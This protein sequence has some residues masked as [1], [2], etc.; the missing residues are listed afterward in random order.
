MPKRLSPP[1]PPHPHTLLKWGGGLETPCPHGSAAYAIFIESPTHTPATQIFMTTSVKTRLINSYI[2]NYDLCFIVIDLII[3]V[4]LTESIPGVELSCNQE[5]PNVKRLADKDCDKQSF[6][7]E[8]CARFEVYI[9]IVF[10]SPTY[11]IKRA[12]LLVKNERKY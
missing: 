6:D 11:V 2:V 4:Q 10:T 9:Y 3:F 5:N 7:W 1:P 8:F 12:L